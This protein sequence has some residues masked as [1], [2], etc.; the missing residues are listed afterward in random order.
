[1]FPAFLLGYAIWRRDWRCLGGCAAGLLVGIVLAPGVALGPQGALDSH[2]RFA[3]VVLLPGL[4]LGGDTSRAFE[5]TDIVTTDSQSLS[6]M[7]HH[8]F[9][10]HEATGGGLDPKMRLLGMGLGLILTGI[11][12]LAAGK[13]RQAAGDER[14]VLLIGTLVINMLLLCPVAHLPYF[15]L[16]LPLVVALVHRYWIPG[17]PGMMGEGSTH[18]FWL[19]SAVFAINFLLRIVPHIPALHFVRYYGPSAYGALL[20]WALTIGLLLKER[21]AKREVQIARPLAA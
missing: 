12:L 20:L 5:L 18:L 2:R 10:G 8:T 15:C 19:L 16:L 17:Y 11:T 21:M 4:G 1:V 7:L 9:H 3:E 13:R 14:E 6:A